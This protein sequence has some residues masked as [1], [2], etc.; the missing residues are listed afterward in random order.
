MRGDGISRGAKKRYDSKRPVVAVRISREQNEKLEKLIRDSG[1][2]KS[3]F[4]RRA[5]RL[6][7]EKK[8]RMYRKGYQE[9]LAKAKDKYTTHLYCRECGKPIPIQGVIAESVV[10]DLVNQSARVYHEDCQPPMVPGETRLLFEKDSDRPV[11]R[12]MPRVQG[13]R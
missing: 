9:G 3:R 10:C 6:E 2:S 11:I 8:D 13:G 4:I 12:T 1:L 7:L 5:L